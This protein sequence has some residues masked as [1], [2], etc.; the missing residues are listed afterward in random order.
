MTLQVF[1][2]LSI[3][4]GLGCLVAWLIGRASDI[5]GAK[6]IATAR[7]LDIDT[8]D[9]ESAVFTKQCRQVRIILERD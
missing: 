9:S 7:K 8:S 2:I 6:D 4:F 3:W 1:M 5:G